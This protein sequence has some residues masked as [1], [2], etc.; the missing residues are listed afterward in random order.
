MDDSIVSDTEPKQTTPLAGQR[1]VMNGIHVL[2]HPLQL[3]EKTLAN[4]PV[5]AT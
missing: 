2:G 3:V 4:A 1:C 5:K